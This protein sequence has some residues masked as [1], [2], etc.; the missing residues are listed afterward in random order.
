MAPQGRSN[1]SIEL[2]VMAVMEG[3]S[4]IMVMRTTSVTRRK[5][6]A[7]RRQVSG[8]RSFNSTR[9]T[10]G[11][12]GIDRDHG[13]RDNLGLGS[14]SG[15][16][17]SNN[18]NNSASSGRSNIDNSGSGSGSG[19][20]DNN[21]GS[22]HNSSNPHPAGNSTTDSSAGN[23][24]TITPFGDAPSI[25]ARQAMENR[26]RPLS[27]MV[28]DSTHDDPPRSGCLPD[29]WAMPCAAASLSLALAWHMAI[30]VVGAC[31]ASKMVPPIEDDD[32]ASLALRRMRQYDACAYLEGIAIVATAYTC[33]AAL[34]VLCR[35][36]DRVPGD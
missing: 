22:N 28:I 16:R 32:A 13:G 26:Q 9:I 2:D 24:N 30:L 19:S 35:R 15:S 11:R 33:A 8:G 4:G 1:A 12:P 31:A 27:P 18:N 23:G 3:T 17:S 21:S 29:P 5:E 25:A 14:S 20:S 36:R 7:G 10:G 34:V 6:T